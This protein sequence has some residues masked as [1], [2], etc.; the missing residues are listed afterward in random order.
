MGFILQRG[1][2]HG[3]GCVPHWRA[4]TSR[5]RQQIGTAADVACV[6]ANRARTSG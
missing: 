3:S 1:E 4:T 2:T 5:Q 6:G